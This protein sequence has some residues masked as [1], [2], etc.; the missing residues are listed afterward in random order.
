[1][2]VDLFIFYWDIK[3]SNIFFDECYNVK[4]VDFGFLKLV[5]MFD[6]NG[7]IL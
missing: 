3:V 2:E 1:M 6:F 4:V 5:F 7:V